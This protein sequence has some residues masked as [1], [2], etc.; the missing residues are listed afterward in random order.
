MF[1]ILEKLEVL[2]L[3]H[4]SMHTIAANT[5]E[6]LSKIESLN[7]LCNCIKE[8]DEKCVNGLDEGRLIYFNLKNNV[9]TRIEH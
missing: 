8:I 7:F 6:K 9:I 2:N 4:N 1:G 3:S 5:F